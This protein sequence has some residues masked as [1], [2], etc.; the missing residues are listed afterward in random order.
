VNL[1]L[2]VVRR[3]EDGFHEL[4]TVMSRISLW[5]TLVF[6]QT[7][8]P[9]V[10]LRVEM[11]YPA[12]VPVPAIPTSEQNLVVRAARL[13]QHA[14][15]TQQ[16]CSITLVKRIPVA[17]GL[18]GG[19]SD[20]A[21]TLTAL[22]QLWELRLSSA[23]L[24]Q[25]GAQLGSDVPFFL[26]DSACVLCTG[27]GERLEPLRSRLRWPLVLAQPSEGLS[28]AEVYRNWRPDQS[29]SLLAGGLPSLRE[30]RLNGP[31]HLLRNDLQS[32]AE[33]VSETVTQ[34]QQAFRQLPVLA[35][36]LTGSG[37][38]FF[39]VA[40]SWRSALT[41]AARLRAAGWPWTC[42]VWTSV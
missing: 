25:V 17:A 35:A 23:E 2:R 42:A 5:D 12:S 31:A 36:Q 9:A 37:S 6:Q 30:G 41:S 4:E 27:R 26:A 34:M 18:G 13:L 20:A 10:A 3:R 39:G 28:T 19:S 1:Y 22:N 8:D 7:A 40:A 29:L 38:A 14:T 15:G 32:A 16:G 33:R 21:A 24:Q 11:A